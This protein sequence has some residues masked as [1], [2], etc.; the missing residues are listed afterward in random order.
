MEGA[1]DLSYA[2]SLT[3]QARAGDAFPDGLVLLPKAGG[4]SSAK[5]IEQQGMVNAQQALS[6]EQAQL[7]NLTWP[8]A[9]DRVKDT[10]EGLMDDWVRQNR[11]LGSLLGKDNRMQGV[12]LL[13]VFLALGGLLI[14]AVAKG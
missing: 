9:V 13:M 2:S 6:H 5:M 7:K 8:K 11:S 3:S 4:Y 12:G 10:V 14:D 1:N